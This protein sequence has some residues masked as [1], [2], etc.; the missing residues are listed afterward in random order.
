MNGCATANFLGP[1]PWGPGEGTKGQISL[2]FNNKVNF[3]DFNTKLV[4]VLT[5]K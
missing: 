2:N 3:Q 1:A 5:N 4:F